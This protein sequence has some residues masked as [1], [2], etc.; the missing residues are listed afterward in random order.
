MATRFTK[1][2]LRA[3][4]SARAG[5]RR[6]H[7]QRCA[8]ACASAEAPLEQLVS[9]LVSWC[10]QRGAE[11]TGLS[12]F[13]GTRGRGLVATRHIASGEV[14]LSVP[15]D[16]C[17]FADDDAP[18][19]DLS[20]EGLADF[21][22][23]PWWARLACR[24]LY[25]R[26]LGSGG[27]YAPALQLIPTRLSTTPLV[28]D[29]LVDL[30]VECYPPAGR[31]C[32]ALR[33]AVAAAYAYLCT[34][35]ES[36]ALL[37]KASYEDF[38]HAV[39]VVH[40]RCYGHF[41]ETTRRWVRVMVPLCDMANHGGDR[42]LPPRAGGAMEVVDDGNLR[43][44]IHGGCLLMS[45]IRDVAPGEEA[46]F[47]YREQSNDH[48][49]LY[50]GF[51]PP[52]N[53]H[54]DLILFDNEDH[55]VSWWTQTYG[56]STADDLVSSVRQAVAAV[57]A[58]VAADPLDLLDAGANSKQLKVLPGL[59]EDNRLDAAFLVCFGGDREQA[60]RAVVQ[61]RMELRDGLERALAAPG[62]NGVV[63]EYLQHKVRL[64]NEPWAQ[65]P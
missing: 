64:A 30:L 51:V 8:C 15:L 38:L 45:A 57:E 12:V 7:R 3:Q 54:D 20:T 21:G 49:L 16:A 11:G 47:S 24:L 2:L 42:A 32:A 13:S 39:A 43:W 17:A 65:T 52:D 60:S 53:A 55:L 14:L 28:D 34:S 9:D 27:E 19:P 58:D 36:E 23:V 37:S 61:R 4:P 40:S 63:R 59:R 56:P 6:C 26:S 46:L 18:R 50:Y 35:A 22:R 1:P 5:L 48:F 62:V 44:D 41:D 10:V 31:Q 29:T 33:N 25:E